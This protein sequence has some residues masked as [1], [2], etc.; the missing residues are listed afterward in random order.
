MSSWVMGKPI[1]I[2]L[3][4]RVIGRAFVPRNCFY[5]E[6]AR[7]AQLLIGKSGEWVYLVFVARYL[8]GYVSLGE[9]I[10]RLFHLVF[11]R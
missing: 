10:A 4:A 1:C 11:C 9:P 3:L 8:A 5:W 2:D 6:M 7:L